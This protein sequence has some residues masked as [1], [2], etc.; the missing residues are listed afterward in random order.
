MGI[1]KGLK[2]KKMSPAISPPTSIPI[3]HKKN[4]RTT[5]LNLNKEIGCP[6]D[7]CD[8]N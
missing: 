4:N 3:N 8:I 1:N 7:I 5:L 6:K 2:Q